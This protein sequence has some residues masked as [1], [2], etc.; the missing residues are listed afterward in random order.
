MTEDRILRSMLAGGLAVLLALTVLSPQVTAQS[1]SPKKA[2]RFAA[3]MAE[4]GNWREATYRWERLLKI[5]PDDPRLLNNLAVSAEVSGEVRQAREYYDKAAALSTDERIEDNRYKFMRSLEERR[6]ANDASDEDVEAGPSPA[7]TAAD[8]ALESTKLG[9]TRSVPVNI[10]IP[11]RLT[12]EGDERLLVVS[13]RAP[14]SELL[15]VNREIVRFMRSEFRKNS[16]LEVL[17]V[18]PPPA[19]PEQR[20]EDLLANRE[21]WQHLSREFDADLVVSGIVGFGREDASAYQNVDLVN[22]ST[23]QKVRDLRFVEQERFDYR[24]DIFFIDGPTGNLL[25][26]DRVERTVL[27]KGQMNDPIAAFFE[28]SESIAGDVLAVVTSRKRVEA[29]LIFKG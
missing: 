26:R 1:M 25:F 27:F 22:P 17:D 8:P 19:I 10:P 5:A 14:E 16:P 15:D 6:H 4:R 24:M 18:L 9:K 3:D 7:V 29:R 13:F 23:G 2:F 11:P 28:L 20:T 21:F 12:L